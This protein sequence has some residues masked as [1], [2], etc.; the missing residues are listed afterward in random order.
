MNELRLLF[1][2]ASNG[3][4]TVRLNNWGGNASQ[5]LPFTPFL[6]DDD[7]ENL[8]WYLEEFMDL[9]DSGSLVRAQRIEAD[10]AAWGRKFYD[11]LFKD[12]DNRELLNHLLSQAPPRL[13]T[14]ATR[15]ARRAAPAIAV[16]TAGRFA[17][18][19]VPAGGHDPP[20]VGNGLQTD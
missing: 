4:Y 11:V 3:D 17:R 19:A 6:E 2:R 16:G 8:R 1:D 13:L 14:L 20:P 9:P 18:P 5:P 7:F 12:G 15:D 10:L